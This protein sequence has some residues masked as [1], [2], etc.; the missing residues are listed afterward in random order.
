LSAADTTLIQKAF[1]FAQEA[2]KQLLTLAVA[3][4]TVTVTFNDDLVKRGQQGQ[5]QHVDVWPAQVGW[6]LYAVSI[7][8]GGWTLLALSGSLERP[9]DGK[10]SIYSANIRW[11]SGAQVLSFVAGV[12]FTVAFGWDAIGA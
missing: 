6:V 8:C 1:D 9:P 3:I 5:H 4:L 11:P 10:H 12:G 2:T 7:L